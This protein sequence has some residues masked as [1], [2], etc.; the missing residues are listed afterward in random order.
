[1]TDCE[2]S[3][4]DLIDVLYGEAGTDARLRAQAHLAACPACRDEHEA[5]RRVRAELPAW[6]LPEVQAQ[7]RRL[8]MPPVARAGLA[9]AAC[10]LLALGAIVVS[11]S[12]LRYEGGALSVRL[13]RPA[14]SP[15]LEARLQAQEQRHRD[16][17]AAL[18]TTLVAPTAAE[19][20]LLAAVDE[21]IRAAEARQAV[22][23]SSSLADFAEKNE[24]QRRYDLA[25]VSQGLS[26]LDRRTGRQLAQ[27]SELMGYVLQAS[28]Q[29]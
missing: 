24:T 16:E 13:G 21:R 27:T 20:P 12:E 6:K 19:S 4:E 18:R 29:R 17:I 9:L 3:R 2:R 5:L 28:D 26:Y 8:G 22:L 7:P 14:A 25:R 23:L 10:L 15:D 11:G 1:M